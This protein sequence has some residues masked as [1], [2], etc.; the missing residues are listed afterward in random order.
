MW[1]IASKI[2][3]FKQMIKSILLCKKQFQEYYQIR[4]VFMFK[5]HVHDEQ[6]MKDFVLPD[7]SGVMF[8]VHVHGRK[9]L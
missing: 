7:K 5:V 8:K 4:V 3:K 2:Y 1:S 9:I 6:A